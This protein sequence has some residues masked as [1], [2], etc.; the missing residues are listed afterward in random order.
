M[1]HLPF[2]SSVICWNMLI[3]YILDYTRPYRVPYLPL[4]VTPTWCN[5]VTSSFAM[6]DVPPYPL[7]LSRA[8]I[9]GT[10]LAFESF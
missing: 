5:D 3:L 10:F 6:P 8:P 7:S 1:L 9:V 2:T 4:C